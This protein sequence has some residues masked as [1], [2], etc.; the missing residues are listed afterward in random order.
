MIEAGIHSKSRK[1]SFPLQV[2][3]KFKMKE[4]DADG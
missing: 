2:F 4:H 3:N 1:I